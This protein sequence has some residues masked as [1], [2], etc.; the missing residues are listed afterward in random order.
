MCKKT[1]QYD[2]PEMS[3]QASFINE[4]RLDNLQ[5]FQERP[6][7]RFGL[8]SSEICLMRNHLLS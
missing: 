2:F 8:L 4:P 1:T 6:T 5:I 7:I 3:P